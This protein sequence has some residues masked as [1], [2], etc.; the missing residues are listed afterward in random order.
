MMKKII[1]ILFLLPCFSFGQSKEF[2]KDYRREL[3]NPS[4][5]FLTDLN[6]IF[7]SNIF[8]NTNSLGK[9]LVDSK[10]FGYETLINDK[11]NSPIFQDATGNKIIVFKDGSI[12]DF[13][14]TPNYSIGVVMKIIYF[15]GDSI[16]NA[17]ISKI[18][19]EVQLLEYSN[20]D[21]R[22][23]KN[24]FNNLKKFL[25]RAY[26][27][28]YVLKETKYDYGT[29]Q[30]LLKD[31]G[32]IYD[33]VEVKKISL[34]SDPI[35]DF[36]ATQSETKFQRLN[37]EGV[38][39]DYYALRFS[40]QDSFIYDIDKFSEQ[41]SKSENKSLN[42]LR[43][44]INDQDMREINEYDLEKMV[45]FFLRDCEKN[46]INVPDIST[47]KARF[48]PLEGNTIAL[49]YGKGDDSII[50]IEVDPEKWAESSSQKRWYVLYHELGHDVL[51]LDH[52]QAGKMM[53]N[54]ANRDYT[55]DEFFE[56]KQYM[57]KSINN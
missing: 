8:F 10:K 53:F 23:I 38:Y 47:L 7:Y 45:S 57:F 48:V 17:L 33:V 49:A 46:N 56:D 44:T 18:I 50:Y 5:I 54:F 22:L 29:E 52:G 42:N 26:E 41:Q 39:N 31:S 40:F 11:T 4:L 16:E 43:F 37:R 6:E 28:R 35:R 3:K 32:G 13:G 25:N 55:W 12:D 30:V 21:V 15:N 2:K 34:K 14:E 1:L 24:Y 36:V 19:N 51:N 9:I 20:T 27:E